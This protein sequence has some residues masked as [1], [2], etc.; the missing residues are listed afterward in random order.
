MI[1]LMAIGDDGNTLAV[2]S[3]VGIPWYNQKKEQLIF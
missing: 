1:N 2:G 3:A